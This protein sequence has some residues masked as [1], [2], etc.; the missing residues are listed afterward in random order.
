MAE[1]VFRSMLTGMTD[2]Q[3]PTAMDVLDP[4]PPAPQRP[5]RARRKIGD[6]EKGV[7]RDLARLPE[8]LREGGIAATALRC[9]LEMDTVPMASRDL[10]AVGGR[11]Q[12]CLDLLRG[13]APGAGSEDT[14]DELRGRRER[15]LEQRRAGAG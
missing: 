10:A 12:Q 1:A 13:W 4:A 8:D 14:T 7:R 3:Q 6:V 5:R 15:Q 9:A 11:L 2:P